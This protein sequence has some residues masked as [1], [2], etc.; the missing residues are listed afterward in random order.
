MAQSSILEALRSSRQVPKT[1]ISVGHDGSCAFRR[2]LVKIS[3]KP[4][5]GFVE[6]FYIPLGN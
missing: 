4:G 6:H 1:G 3:N 2:V 5:P